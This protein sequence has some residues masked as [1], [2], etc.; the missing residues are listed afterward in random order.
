MPRPSP[1]KLSRGGR[2][3]LLT[4]TDQAIA[5]NSPVS[6]L[7]SMNFSVPTGVGANWT[8][9]M[10]VAYQSTVA[11]PVAPTVFSFQPP[12]LQALSVSTGVTSGGFPVTISG[13]NFGSPEDFATFG[14]H[15]QRGVV[16][17]RTVQPGRAVP[18]VRGLLC[19]LAF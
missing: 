12:Q 17:Q 3:L 9:S 19:C 4:P 8:L 11:P 14:R 2:E 5:P 6:Q 7:Q 15:A 1:A 18:F 13:S 10:E 16:L